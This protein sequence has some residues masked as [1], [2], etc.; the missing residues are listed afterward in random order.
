[1]SKFLKNRIMK[2]R[3]RDEW[4]NRNSKGDNVETMR[5]Q[6]TVKGYANRKHTF[7]VETTLMSG[8]KFITVKKNGNP[9][10]KC[11]PNEFARFKT[12]FAGDE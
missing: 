12:L 5:K 2:N 10:L 9:I 3:L 7:E 11:E 4:Y 6:V 8:Y 1:M